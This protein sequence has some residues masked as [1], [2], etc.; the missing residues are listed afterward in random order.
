VNIGLKHIIRYNIVSNGLKYY[1]DQNKLKGCS[2]NVRRM[3][4]ALMT[5]S[6]FNNENIT[7]MVDTYRK[8]LRENET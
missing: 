2:R 7:L 1:C 5:Y 8:R 6:G 4:Y 3:K